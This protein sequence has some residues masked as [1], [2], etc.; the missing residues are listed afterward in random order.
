MA[1]L[2]RSAFLKPAATILV[3][4]MITGGWSFYGRYRQAHAPLV[5]GG[6]AGYAI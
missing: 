4:C 3:F 1:F 2:N 6:P 5:D